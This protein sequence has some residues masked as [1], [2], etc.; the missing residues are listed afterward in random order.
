MNAAIPNTDH[1]SPGRKN[2]PVREDLLMICVAAHPAK[3]GERAVL[4]ALHTRETIDRSLFFEKVLGGRFL[5]TGFA[6]QEKSFGPH[7]RMAHRLCGRETRRRAIVQFNHRGL[8]TR[9]DASE[10]MRCS[11]RRNGRRE[12]IKSISSKGFSEKRF[13]TFRWLS[14][15]DGVKLF[16]K[17]TEAKM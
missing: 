5:S 16:V 14:A 10:K 3:G 17:D 9:F 7:R 4:T 1:G 6:F 8:A 13:F 12:K 11:K 2:N 15:G